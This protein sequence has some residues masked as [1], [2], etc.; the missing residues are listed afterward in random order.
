MSLARS[1][2]LSGAASVIMTSWE[3][4]DEVSADIMSRFYYYLAKGEKKDDALH[5]AKIDFLNNS[6]PSLKNPYYWAAYKVL[7]NNNSVTY[8]RDLVLFLA[9][10]LLV[11]IAGITI[12]FFRRRRISPAESL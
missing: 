8:N 2:F 6:P 10:A 7:G 5:H 9:S 3:I 4:N 12:Y 11:I 1:F